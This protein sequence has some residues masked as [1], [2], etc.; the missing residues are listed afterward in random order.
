MATF[1]TSPTL[2]PFICAQQHGGVPTLC[3]SIVTSMCCI[4]VYCMR[5]RSRMLAGSYGSRGSSVGSSNSLVK[6]GKHNLSAPPTLNTSWRPLSLQPGT[7]MINT[8]ISIQ[9]QSR[10]PCVCIQSVESC[11]IWPQRVRVLFSWPRTIVQGCCNI[12]LA[13]FEVVIKRLTSCWLQCP[14]AARPW[15]PCR[16]TSQ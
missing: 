6:W 4:H 15:L 2:V 10:C 1:W 9:A 11:F 7:A 12:S 8:I 13:S 14:A 5:V 16:H 3:D